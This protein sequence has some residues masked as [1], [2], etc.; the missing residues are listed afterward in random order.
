M[1]WLLVLSA[2]FVIGVAAGDELDDLLSK[3]R[4][5][6]WKERQEAKKVLME[7]A[8]E[9]TE[10]LLQVAEKEKD[11]EV[12]EA[13]AEVLGTVKYPGP[14]AIKE[15]ERT[16]D[17][18]LKLRTDKEKVQKEGK[19]LVE[20]LKKLKNI[21]H[22]FVWKLVR[23]E[24]KERA[25]AMAE[26]LWGLLSE[27]FGDDKVVIKGGKGGGVRMKVVVVVAG[28][29]KKVQV[30]RN[31]KLVTPG[32]KP[33]LK[34]TP[35]TALLR[36]LESE[37]ALLVRR[38]LEA[39]AKLGDK[40]AVGAIAPLLKKKSLPEE[41][42]STAIEAL[43]ALTGTVFTDKKDLKEHREA[44]QKWWDENRNNPEFKPPKME[45]DEEQVE[46]P[47]EEEKEAPEEFEKMVEE[48]LKR[49]EKFMKEQPQAP[50]KK[51]DE[52]RKMLEKM[53]QKEKDRKTPKKEQPESQKGQKEGEF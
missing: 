1:R 17:E 13:L 32:G 28:G 26:L 49:L 14:G 11:P 51:L 44:W 18:W 24:D 6:E 15:A 8:E 2:V 50:F 20:G 23:T 42:L 16:L 40:R 19:R 34:A 27:D 35:L 7:R 21:E 53:R 25:K 29:K 46:E 4:S 31:G 43:K 36:A 12:C 9:F 10:R 48:M 37:D 52:M 5:D 22:W 3:L 45:E 30:W 47:K 41:T 38:A 33:N 39:L